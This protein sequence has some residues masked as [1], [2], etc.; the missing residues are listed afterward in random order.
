MCVV[1]VQSVR[2]LVKVEH[3]VCIDIVCI[4]EAWV[5]G[6]VSVT[7][8]KMY[9]RIVC[10]HCK[11]TTTMPGVHIKYTELYISKLLNM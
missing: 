7:Y 2:S 3:I 11:F 4:R 5:M 9:S 1:C 8:S 6:D 10:T